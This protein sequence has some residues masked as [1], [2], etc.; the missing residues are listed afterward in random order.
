MTETKRM[1]SKHK[2]YVYIYLDP[3]K[4]GK[5]KYSKYKFT[6]EPLYI[7]KGHDKRIVYFDR[8]YNPLL[9]N[10]LHKMFFPI[11]LMIKDNL[12]EEEAFT[13]EIKA[14]ATIGRRDQGKGPLCNMT[15]GGEGNS[16]YTHSEGSKQKMRNAHIGKKIGPM[17][18][19]YKQKHRKPIGPMPEAIKQKHREGTTK[20]WQSK[21]MRQK[22]KESQTHE[23]RSIAAKKAWITRRKKQ[24]N[25]LENMLQ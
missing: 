12:T 2:F 18:E 25:Y 14:I 20:T 8:K 17:P 23:E 19:E 3:R 21:E 22:Y 10:K 5:Y 9:M 24:K 13:E 1:K 6:Y 7:G 16:G 11:Y 4:P 15:D